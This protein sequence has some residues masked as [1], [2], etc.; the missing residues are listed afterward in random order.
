[1]KFLLASM[2]SLTNCEIP[3]SNTLLG[4][5]PEQ[6]GIL[7]ES[8]HL[9]SMAEDLHCRHNNCISVHQCCG[10]GSGIRCFFDP[11]IRDG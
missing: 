5:Y 11:W 2:K 6:L 8:S 1:M 4:V 7:K 3:S 9:K 10:S